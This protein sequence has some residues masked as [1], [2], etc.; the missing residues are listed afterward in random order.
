MPGD[1]QSTGCFPEETPIVTSPTQ[2]DG[3]RF[4]PSTCAVHTGEYRDGRPRARLRMEAHDR[5]IVFPRADGELTVREAIVFGSDGT[6]FLHYDAA[7]ASGFRVC[8]AV[9]S[10][11]ENWERRGVVLGPGPAGA[12]DAAAAVSPW[13]AHDGPW[14]HM[15]Y[16][17]SPVFVPGPERLPGFPYLTLK[18]RSRLPAGPWEKQP[19]VI[20]FGVAPGTYRSITASPG[21]IIRWKGQWLMYFSATT[22][23]P[24]NPCPLRTLAIARS[25]DLD[26]PWTVDEHPALPSE[27]QVENSAI[28]Y[29][30]SNGT[31]FLFTNH[32]GIEDYEYTDAIWV[33]WSRDPERWDPRSKAVVLDGRNCTWAKR[34]IG[35]PSVIRHGNRLALFYDGRSGEEM[36]NETGSHRGRDIGLAWLDLPLVPPAAAKP[37]APQP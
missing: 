12:P 20:P 3:R 28:S 11:L 21:C 7:F 10:D 18:A 16:V 34:I 14:W 4:P 25:A 5:G 37:D 9:S 23:R 27:E 30:P 2:V 6:F 26:G 33:Y 13:V 1:A 8:L 32:I 19:D 35:M 17:G 24:D 36:P 29:E 15:F 22:T 31:W